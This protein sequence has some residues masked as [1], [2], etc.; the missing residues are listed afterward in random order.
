MWIQGFQ[1]FAWA[2][3][4]QFTSPACA[5]PK[6]RETNQI[7]TKSP[8][9]LFFTFYDDDPSKNDS[10]NLPF[11]HDL[12]QFR[13]FLFGGVFF[14][15]ISLTLGGQ[16]FSHTSTSSPRLRATS[17]ADRDGG[18]IGKWYNTIGAILNFTWLS[19]NYSIREMITHKSHLL[20]TGQST[21]SH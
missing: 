19:Q 12:A 11:H 18:D 13:D 15:H 10:A 5:H 20:F 7:S 16:N 6:N 1:R 8:F 9:L 21:N 14:L 3:K 17:R 4:D 2:N